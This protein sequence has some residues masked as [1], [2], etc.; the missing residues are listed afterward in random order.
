[1]GQPTTTAN[2]LLFRDAILGVDTNSDRDPH[3]E[4]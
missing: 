4:A 1:L 2:F 3:H